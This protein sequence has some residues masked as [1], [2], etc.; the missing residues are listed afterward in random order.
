VWQQAWAKAP[1]PIP[2]E[3]RY[4]LPL[5]THL[6]DTAAIMARLWDDWAG[7][8]PRMVIEA[9]VNDA[10]LA[11]SIAILAAG[12]H[13]LG[14]HSRAFAGQVPDMRTHMESHGYRWAPSAVREDAR[15]LPHSIVGHVMVRE[16]LL[17]NGAM[18]AS[19]ESFAVVIG[20]HHGVPPTQAQL[21][22]VKD[23]P[24]L[25]GDLDWDHARAELVDHV[26]GKL[27][28]RDVLPAVARVQLSDAAQMLLTGL[29]ITADWLASNAELFPLVP[30]FE[31]PAENSSARAAHAWRTLALPAPWR[32]I[33]EALSGDPTALLR[34]RFPGAAG[35]EANDVQRLSLR[36]AREMP[37]VGLVIV[38]AVMG[39]GKTEASM[40]AAEVL[41]SRFGRSGVFY[42]LPTR[43]TTDAMFSRV[44][45]WWRVVPDERGAGGRSVQLRHSGAPLNAE[46]RSLP[47]AGAPQEEG[48]LTG[49]PAEVGTDEPSIGQWSGR[50]K[51]DA[52]AVAHYWT[53]GRKKAALADAVIA[54]IDHELLSALAS[55]HVVL[56]HLGLARQVVILDEI[57]AADTWMRIY[58]LRALEWLGRYAVP[59]IALSATLPPD[60]RTAL[61][62]AYERGRRAGLPRPT[63]TDHPV[64]GLPMRSTRAQAPPLP[65]APATDDY[66]VLT[67][68]SAGK[69]SQLTAP[70]AENRHVELEWTADENEGLADRVAAELADGGCIAVVCNT[71]SRAIARYRILRDRF[72][73]RVHL[74]HSRFIA[75]DRSQNDEWLRS[76]FGPPGDGADGVDRTDRDGQIV[77]ATQVVEQSLDID[78]DLLITDLAPIDLVLQRMGRLH[79]HD[80]PRPVRLRTPRCLITAFDPGGV[81]AVERGA[82]SVY[83]AHLLLRSAA[84]VLEIT[85]AGGTVKLP[86]DVPALVRRCYGDEA[87]GP[88]AWRQA[89]ADAAEAHRQAVGGTERNAT[90]YLLRSP[91]KEATVVGMLTVDAGEAD[92]DV[93]G[94]QQVREGDGGFEVI[95]LE[96]A[97]DGLRLLPHLDDDRAIPTD[98]RPDSETARLVSRCIVRV[99]AWVTSSPWQMNAVLDDLTSVYFQPWQRDPLLGG[100]LIL[101]LDPS[102]RGRMGP[103]AVS[104]DPVIGLEVSYDRR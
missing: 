69:V 98:R 94:T 4:W 95:L 35:F 19:A 48:P 83:G 20:G 39:G 75:H 11:R 96:S 102:G 65:H 104:Y 103:Y 45:P 7:P 73:D 15:R 29:V 63:S 34:S 32:P 53:S 54:T 67:Y 51:A 79:R 57:H 81:P 56:R 8:G 90:N 21:N 46:F 68:V 12:L 64:L 77:V 101:L 78:F 89:M 59:V 38:E 18:P 70:P 58:L 86:Q 82:A 27:G 93:A 9:D 85:G 41:A 88:S 47:R 71:V 31:Q 3:R 14:K 84:L 25:V 55:R 33:R 50:R 36:A 76:T 66:P 92:T 40:L 37:D 43:A 44:L 26:L 17:H 97:D 30:A 91:G 13:D 80:R 61:I 42:G 16:L 99:P 23:N 62:R 49:L 22:Q 74:A 60:Q 10:D 100:Q 87:L 6:T 72:G 2:G 28:L 5:G 24:R 1:S 52:E